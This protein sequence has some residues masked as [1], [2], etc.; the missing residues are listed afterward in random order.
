VS[1]AT[2]LAVARD[3]E[4][5]V[6]KA[7]Q[8]VTLWGEFCKDLI[9]IVA[10]SKRITWPAARFQ[11]DP[12]GFS[13]EILGVELWEKQEEIL[14][15]LVTHKRVSV[16]SGHKIGK[17]HTAVVAAL[18][19][20]C[21]FSDARVVMSS[22][23]SRQVDAILWRELKKVRKDAMHKRLP[24]MDG[25]PAVLARSGMRSDDLREIVGFTASESE[26][27]AG[28]SG[29]N[30]LY[31]IDE[32]SGVD[33]AIYEAIEGNR[34]GGGEEGTNV[35][36]LL[37]GNPTRT[38]GE[39]FRSQTDKKDHYK[40]IHVSSEDTPNVKQGRIVIPGLATRA[41]VEE[42][43]REWGEE[44]ALYQV[45]V[46]GNFAQESETTV[47]GLHLVNEA[48]ARHDDTAI[49]LG[50]RLHIGV[51]VARYGD[52][53]TAIAVRRGDKVIHIETHQKLDEHQVA[54]R[55]IQAARRW[56]E[57]N[58]IPVVKIDTCGTVGIRATAALA[59]NRDAREIELVAVNVGN[60][61]YLRREFP[62]L[63]DQLWFA[64]ATWL[65]EGGSIPDES[66]LAAEL[67]APSFSFDSLQRR[68]VESKDDIR[69]RLKRSPDRADAVCLAVWDPAQFRSENQAPDDQPEERGTAESSF[70]ADAYT[71]NGGGIY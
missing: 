10:D 20:Y 8:K 31:I 67:V 16:R 48:I 50:A 1:T 60:K 61:A 13:D 58:E 21:S 9:Q 22:V 28:V 18:W 30:L 42:K 33:D 14:N 11:K 15:A 38:V 32:A 68:R 34:A 2:V 24:P 71:Q 5:R 70:E 45:R 57:P 39:F 63:R 3:P 41:W 40:V 19:F 56:R 37:L 62:L 12:V 44:S 66:K 25:E 65:R 23:T 47:I 6:R 49:D 17:S 27:V 35:I 29:A 55:V 52:D 54:Y 53:E 51:D 7:A 64:C 69:K 4:V 26:A 43:R 36:V 46:R 59:S